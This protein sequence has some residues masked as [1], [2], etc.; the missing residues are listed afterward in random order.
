MQNYYAV[1]LRAVNVSGKNLIR[2]AELRDVLAKNGFEQV[3]TYI[4]SGNLIVGTKLKKEEAKAY[5]QKL[6]TDHFQL[7]VEAFVWDETD[8]L[9]AL[10]NNPFDSALPGNRVFITILDKTPE[11]KLIDTFHKID[12]GTE[13]FHIKDNTFYF[14][15]PDGMAKSKLSNNFIENKLQV[16]S[17]GRNINTM[18]KVFGL[19]K[20]TSV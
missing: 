5:V 9:K 18:H 12:I 3:Q 8:V 6:I 14:Y 19:L 4:Q 15:V 2:M 16:R 13:Q 17:T 7:S 20:E 11:K 1:F 10:M